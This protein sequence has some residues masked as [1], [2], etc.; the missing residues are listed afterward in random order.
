[1]ENELVS[2]IIPTYNREKMVGNAIKSVLNQTYKNIEVIVV[3][4]GSKDNTQE[5]I[6]SIGDNRIRYI[7]LEKNGGVSR[8]RNIGINE[9]KGS[10]IAFQDSDDVWY[11]NKLYEE[12]K[13][14]Q[15]D[16]N[17]Q[18]VFC[19][20]ECKTGIYRVV[21]AEDNFSLD[22]GKDG[23]LK[24]LLGGNKIGMP[25]VLLKRE[26]LKKTGVFNETL[27]TLEDWELFLRI[28]R[29]GKVRFLK[30]VLVTVDNSTEGVNA[31]VGI[32]RAKTELL[33]LRDYWNQYE[34]K[35]VFHYLISSILN[36]L[37]YMS[38][39]EIQA[40]IEFLKQ[41][42]LDEV[43]IRLI[44]DYEK[45]IAEYQ[46]S[47]QYL[48][49]KLREQENYNSYLQDK[50]SEQQSYSSYLQGKVNEQ[51][52]YCD[53][54]QNKLKEY[55]KYNEFLQSRLKEHEKYKKYLESK[56]KK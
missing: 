25:T 6:K 43:Y 13:E 42:E 26:I 17:C 18:M 29:E 37:T 5:V 56:L 4:D 51:E 55:Q 53:Y 46:R 24:S 50:L 52:K 23:L 9:A 19:K 20:Y 8:A 48:N 10:F 47:S 2:V 21:P 11:T 35:Q 38:K 14:M 15:S 36:D 22:I 16:E 28:T 44:L 7:R 31:L 33:I 32:Q 27:C 40:C 30:K 45:K 12:M 34:D 3:D 49:G 1:M 39:E 41:Y 54:L